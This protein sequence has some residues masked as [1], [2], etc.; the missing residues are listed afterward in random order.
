M[1][2]HEPTLQ[3]AFRQG[4]AWIDTASAPQTF[5]ALAPVQQTALLE[6]LA[7]K[8]NFR[9]EEKPGQEFFSVMRRYTVMG[10]YTTRLGLEALDYPGLRF[11]AESPSVPPSDLQH[12]ALA[13]LGVHA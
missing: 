2:A 9:P 7:Y 11:Y 5:T 3:P 10:F 12:G 1:V 4:L 13:Q 6:R 8:R